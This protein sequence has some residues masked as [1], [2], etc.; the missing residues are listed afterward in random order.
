MARFRFALEPLLKARADAEREKQRSFATIEGERLKLEQ[1]L[2]HHQSRIAEGKQS[3]RGGLI[4]TIDAPSLRMH[5]AASL[6]LMRQAQRTVLELA[7]VHKRLD[8]AR[9]ELIEARRRRRA[10]EILKEH[11][12]AEWTQAL[13]KAETAA[14]DEM[15]VIAAARRQRSEP[16]AGEQ[17]SQQ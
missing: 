10:I 15:A 6:Q 11:R 13:E 3:L 1:A 9:A 7:G 8:A 4:G 2:R 17:G 12:L 16:A 14:L 5:A